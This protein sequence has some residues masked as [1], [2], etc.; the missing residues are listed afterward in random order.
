MLCLCPPVYEHIKIHSSKSDLCKRL[1]MACMQSLMMC[2]RAQA[3][4]LR[5][6]GRA[7]IRLRDARLAH[8][9]AARRARLEQAARARRRRA[10]RLEQL[11]AEVHAS[12]HPHCSTS[13]AL[14]KSN[15]PY[16]NDLQSRQL[17]HMQHAFRQAMRCQQRCAGAYGGGCRPAAPACADCQL[18]RRCGAAACG[19]QAAAWFFN[20]RNP[21]GPALPGAHKLGAPLFA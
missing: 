10:M 6:R 21:A 15:D 3:A 9:Q 13:S 2:C 19:V 12:K 14:V 16:A 8:R 18:S 11:R 20:Y 1:G 4:A 5:V 17:K 7:R